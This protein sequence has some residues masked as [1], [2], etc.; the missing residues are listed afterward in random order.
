ML[1]RPGRKLQ[2]TGLLAPYTYEAWITIACTLICSTIMLGIC[3]KISNREKKTD[4]TLHFLDS[5]H[6]LC[7]RNMMLPGFNAAHLGGE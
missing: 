4:W 1:Q 7:G 2:W 3:L 6:P 5:L